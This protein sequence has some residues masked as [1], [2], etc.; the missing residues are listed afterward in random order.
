MEKKRIQKKRQNPKPK[1]KIR[2]DRQTI[3][4]EIK[5]EI[6]RPRFWDLVEVKGS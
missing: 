5:A 1:S 4:H 2:R 3:A 6:P